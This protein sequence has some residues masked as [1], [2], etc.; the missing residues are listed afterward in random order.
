MMRHMILSHSSRCGDKDEDED[1]ITFTS[2]LSSADLHSSH[3]KD[4]YLS[5]V[6]STQSK[7]KFLMQKKILS[8]NKVVRVLEAPER[9][10]TSMHKVS[11]A[12][13]LTA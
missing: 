10:R 12:L 6:F 8:L 1:D 7:L 3:T 4:M 13:V 9:L 11:T 5:I 2:S